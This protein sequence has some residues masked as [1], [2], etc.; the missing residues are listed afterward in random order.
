[1]GN[2]VNVIRNEIEN[3]RWLHDE[4]EEIDG[5]VSLETAQTRVRLPSISLW[6][7]GLLT[8]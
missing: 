1:M 4:T 6:P 3:N 5:G 7:S 8:E 2:G